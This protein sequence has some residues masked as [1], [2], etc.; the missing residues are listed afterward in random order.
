MIGIGITNAMH[1]PFN[2]QN[3]TNSLT[4]K[5]NNNN[6]NGSPLNRSNIA[7]ITGKKG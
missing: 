1:Y 6:K 7:Y 4:E 5:K 3:Q 2:S